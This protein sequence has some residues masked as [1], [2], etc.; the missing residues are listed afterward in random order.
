MDQNINN[1][2]NTAS[3]N[4]KWKLIG[5]IALIIAIG[6]FAVIYTQIST[7]NADYICTY[8]VEENDPC[9]NGSW[10]EWSTISTTGDQ[11]QCTQV[12]TESRVYTGNRET[13]HILQYLTLRTACDAGYSQAR[14]GNRRDASG[15]HGGNIV[16]ESTACQIEES[17]TVTN[18]LS[19]QS[20]GSETTTSVKK[21]DIG[22]SNKT[23]TSISA[24][25]QLTQF[26]EEKIKGNIT[27][28]P[29]LLRR[30][31]S[32]KI[33]WQGVE[34]TSCIVT[35]TNGDSWSGTS[36]EEI[37]TPIEAATTFT[38]SC[39][40]FNDTQVQESVEVN[41]IPEFQEF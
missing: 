5:I 39:T 24:L 19:G 28:D 6:G 17:R 29:E 32:T 3:H 34:T 8:I 26:R 31:T 21:N 40:A 11:S 13:R 16:S 30:G 36:G 38:L 14:Y 27:V 12:T 1:N 41:I 9:G 23:E 35:G 33:T 7:A 25:E 22:N 20:C 18:V 10:S 2:F 4:K 15:F 37:S